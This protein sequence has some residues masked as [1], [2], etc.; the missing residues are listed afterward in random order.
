MKM[1]FRTK[2]TKSFRSLWVTLAVSFSALILLVLLVSSGLNMYL[3]YQTQRNLVISQQTLIAQNAAEK[4]KDFIKDELDAMKAAVSL[5][6]PVETNHEEQ[7]LILEK[8][9]GLEPAFR[10]AVLLDAEGQELAR[11][12]RLSS[13]V[14]GHLT[15]HVGEDVFSQTDSPEVYISPVYINKITSEPLVIM[16]VSVRNVFGDFEGALLAEVNLKFMWDLVSKIKVGNNGFAYV[17]DMRGNLIAFGDIS[18]VLRGENLAYLNE[19]EEFVTGNFELHTDSAEVVEGING[20]RVVANHAHL[21]T[22]NWAVIVEM[23]VLEAY[24]SILTTFVVSLFIIVLSFAFA[25]I[26]GIYLSKKIT[27]PITTLRDAAAR[28]GEGKLDT[29]IEIKKKDEI[30]ILAAALNQMAKDLQSTTT[31]IEELNREIENR[32]YTEEAL[33]KNQEFTRRIIESSSDCIKVLDL[34]G[35]L[36]SMSAGGQKLLEIEDMAPYLNTSFVDFWKGEERKGCLEA[37]AK[38]KHGDTGLFYGY[39]ETVKGKPKWWEVI[40]T[41][42]KDAD[43]SIERLLAVS[44]DITE[45]KKSEEELSRL[46]SLYT[47]T[48]EATADGILVVDFNGRVVGH[49]KKYLELWRIP[50]SL[51]KEG[52]DEK[53][54]AHVLDQLED[55]AGF[56]AEVRRLYSSINEHSLDI[57]R[58]KDGRVFERFS[59]P[60][61]VKDR[62]V[63]RVWSFRDVT[64]QKKAE[65]D[66]QVSEQRFKQVIECA[67]DWI[68]EIDREGLFTYSSPVST[69]VLGYEPNEIVGKKYFYDF[70]A[71]VDREALKNAA[72][73]IF[74]KAESFQGFIS[75][76]INRNGEI[77]F[78]ET[79]GTPIINDTGNVCGYRGAN[80]DISERKKAEQNRIQL[81]EKLAKTNQELNDFV[82]VASHDLKTPLRGIATLANWISTDFAD[83]LDE[84]GKEKMELLMARVERMYSLIMGILR[85]SKIARIGEEKVILDLNE[86]VTDVVDM[87][88]PPEN[89][90]V[91]IEN[92]LP[93]I[94][95]ERTP[96]TQIFENLIINAVKFMDKPEGWIKIACVEEGDVWKFS[97]ADNGPGIEEKYFTKIFQLFQTLSPRDEIGGTGMG[98]SMVKK[99][100]EM[101]GGEVW[102][103][104]Q[105]G[106]GSTFFFVLPKKEREVK[107]ER[108]QQADIVS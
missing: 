43:G 64:A 42:I 101:Y 105:L 104:S 12:S 108:L 47:A 97:V 41:P 34:Q 78:L 17:V 77:I 93:V 63:G 46:L 9:L 29:E 60:Q 62:I 55:P 73:E 80:R 70:F 40:V 85:Y 30:G 75:P 18:R 25:I 79:N 20:N 100:V 56:L 84:E 67:G 37:I 48:L 66:L 57:I 3:S 36:L 32:K 90:S 71:P 69:N 26:L 92:Q 24:R 89:I 50:E 15:D 39:F 44:R 21:G 53:L 51:V 98:L 91:T 2:K 49:N 14:S 7:M 96:I 74:A 8:L 102:V 106:R 82:Y 13:L 83:K 103:E 45:R 16:A 58:F 54:L 52:D 33:R 6:N 99:I 88:N 76:N 87:V 65:E 68:W 23:P 19:V 38:A 95:Y 28:I 5:S 4:V 22:P 31:S 11:V 1:F 86:L 27:K 61:R 107:N 59:Q 10:Q 35:N 94:E 81:L 72:F